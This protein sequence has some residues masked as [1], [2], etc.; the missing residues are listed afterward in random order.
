MILKR[1]DRRELMWITVPLLS[2]A[3]SGAVYVTGAG[4]RLTEPVTN[5]ISLVD[6]DNSG[7]ITPKSYAG[8]FTPQK[9]SIRIEAGAGYDIQPMLMNNGYYGGFSGNNSYQGKVDSKVVIGPR[10][11]LEFYRNGVWSMKTM[12]IEADE[13]IKGKLESDLNYA[14]GSFS[15]TIK[16]TSGFDLEE[17]YII[18]PSQYASIG[19]VKNGETKQVEIKPVNYYG[20]RYD[21]INAIY[22]DPYSGSQNR[23][24]KYK[25]EE[26]AQIRKNNQKRQVLEYSFMNEAYQGFEARLMAWSSTPVAGEL[27]VNGSVVKGYEKSLITSKVNMSFRE[28]NTVEYPLGFLKP[29][30]IN[31]QNNGNYDEYGRTFY[32]RGTFEVHYKI[33]GS[34]AVE[35]IRTQYT[36]GNTQRV[37]QYLW[38]VREGAWAEGDYRGFD[39][40]GDLLG[41]YIDGDNTLK[42]KI[43]MDEDNVQLPLISVKGSVK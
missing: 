17:C 4:T 30:I 38:D 40:K 2:L 15:G 33:D 42:I 20:Q 35:S 26:I 14:N 34:I 9:E 1:L 10:T 27:L 6:I 23:N 36:V 28:G 8:I 25:P 19:P 16:N 12:S 32:G 41:R 37:R 7:T 13:T 3:F 24:T 22:K 39:I 5:V 21:L 31:N 18:T 29:T 43:E 11:T